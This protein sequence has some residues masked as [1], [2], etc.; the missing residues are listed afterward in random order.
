M[1][2]VAAQLR[3]IGQLWLSMLLE[4]FRDGMI[5]YVLM[6]VVVIGGLGLAFSG[7]N[8]KP[9]RVAVVE[10]PEAARWAEM[11]AREPTLEVVR[12]ELAEAEQKLQVGRVVLVVQPGT[13]PEIV[14]D[15]TQDEGRYA[16]MAVFHALA[17]PAGSP[18]G[19]ELRERTIQAQGRRYVDFMVPG[20]LGMMLMDGATNV[21]MTLVQ[22]RQRRLLKRYAATPMRRWHYLVSHALLSISVVLFTLPLYYVVG[23]LMFGVRVLGSPIG[24]VLFGVFGM[25]MLSGIGVLLGSRAERTEQTHTIFFLTKIPLILLSGALFS[26][27]RFPDWAQPILHSLPLTAFIDGLRGTMTGTIGFLDLGRPAAVLAIWGLATTALALKIFRW[28]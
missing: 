25:L 19:P 21:G 24:F 17:H 22:D 5:G 2:G 27:E 6:P 16:R 28:K 18:P 15:P 8:N 26:L 1:R 12:L 11:L 10:G 20:L 7:G 9:V 14:I 4:W 23:R 13:P 3:A